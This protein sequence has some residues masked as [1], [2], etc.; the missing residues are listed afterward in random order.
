[1]GRRLLLFVLAV[2]ALPALALA[3]GTDPKKQINPVD[4][5]NAA[6]IVLKRTDFVA[7]WK[8]VPASP[9]SDLSCPGFNPDGSDLTLTGEAEADFEHTQGIPSVLSFSEIF[10]SKSDALKSWSRTV[11]PAIARCI[12]HFFREGMVEE[13][14]TAKIL[15]Q[16]RIAFPKLAPRTAAFRVVASVT[17]ENPGQPPTTVPF[18]IH[19]IA[20]GHGRGDAGLLTMGFGNGVATADLRAF[21]K[22]LAVRLA[23]AKL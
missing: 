10:V 7:G 8:K 12:A 21:A 4:Q 11:K 23:A 14:G 9:D 20:L 17:I 15:K 3:A 19:L 1:V 22:L 6:S 16:G 5:R 13:G 2:L 18:T